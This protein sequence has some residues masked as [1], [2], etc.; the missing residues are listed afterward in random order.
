MPLRGAR[1][2]LVDMVRPG[3]DDREGVLDLLFGRNRSQVDL[4]VEPKKIGHGFACLYRQMPGGNPRD[5]LVSVTAPRD[6]FI[7]DGLSVDVKDRSIAR[8]LS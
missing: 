5:N 7:R 8:T 3:G 6:I 2:V 4:G 1:G